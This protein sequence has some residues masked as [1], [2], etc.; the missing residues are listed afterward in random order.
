MRPAMLLPLLTMLVAQAATPFAGL[1]WHPFS[2][3]DLAW[4]EDGRTS[5]VGVGE[6]DG[7]ARPAL[8]PHF[9]AW[10]SNRT[11]ISLTIGIARLQN[12]TLVDDIY[13]QRHWGVIR[14]GI[15]VRYAFVDRV[16]AKPL[17]WVILGL[18]GDIPS[19]RDVSNG[20][21][22]DE[23]KAADE[24]AVNERTRLGGAGARAG[25]GAD[26]RINPHIAFGFLYALELHR[27]ILETDDT[28]AVTS[29]LS[30][31]AALTLTFEWPPPTD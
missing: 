7:V 11:A 22:P 26:Y 2:R 9:G 17:P 31:S 12:T 27:S 8:S 15:D 20:Y 25:F 23:Q 28:S 1:E 18:H 24:L 13:R 6:F 10:V 29:W 5:G 16:V 30:G 21:T 14:P 4:I 3:A 19:A